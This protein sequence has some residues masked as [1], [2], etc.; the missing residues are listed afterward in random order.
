MEGSTTQS[1][2]PTEVREIIACRWIIYGIVLGLLG[3]GHAGRADGRDDASD[4]G[5]AMG[6]LAW[7]AWRLAVGF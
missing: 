2:S 1:L 5:H 7:N 3:P 6:G 4:D